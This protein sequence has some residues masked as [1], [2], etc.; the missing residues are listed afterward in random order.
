MRTLEQ[1]EITCAKKACKWLLNIESGQLTS[2]QHIHRIFGVS[3]VA[4]AD[5]DLSSRWKPQM[6]KLLAGF[7]DFLWPRCPGDPFFAVATYRLLVRLDVRADSLEQVAKGI[8]GILFGIGGSVAASALWAD[9]LPEKAGCYSPP[10]QPAK[11]CDLN[12]LL[13]GNREILIETCRSL[14]HTSSCGTIPVSATHLETVLP[15]LCVSYARSFDIQAVC[16]LLRAC[17]YLQQA[18]SIHCRWAREWLLGQQ[19]RDGRFGLLEIEAQR[20]GWSIDV[21]S[22]YLVPTIEAVWTLAELR[23]PGVLVRPGSRS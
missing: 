20:A 19:Q 5:T 3:T 6:R 1:R 7:P 23:R 17:V 8:G 16:G 11:F 21:V 14:M 10:G 18:N 4:A 9:L 12:E 2:E 15:M 22:L 13:D